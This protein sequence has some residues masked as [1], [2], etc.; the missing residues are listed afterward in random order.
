MINFLQFDFV[1]DS[2]TVKNVTDILLSK[3]VNIV[4]KTTNKIS[5][6]FDKLIKNFK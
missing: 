4:Q 1:E 2:Y 3:M 6:I 5:A